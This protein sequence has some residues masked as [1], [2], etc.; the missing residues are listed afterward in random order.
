MASAAAAKL[1]S[2]T[3]SRAP[4]MMV[5]YALKLKAGLNLKPARSQKLTTTVTPKGTIMKIP[6]KTS[7]RLR[8]A[9]RM[10]V[11]RCRIGRPRQAALKRDHSDS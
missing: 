9:C 7:G 5:S 6:T 3:S 1:R 11:A 2:S 4:S 8:R 10:S